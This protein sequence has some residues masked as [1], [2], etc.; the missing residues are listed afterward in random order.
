MTKRKSLA[1][2]MQSVRNGHATPEKQIPS[3]QPESTKA[4]SDGHMAKNQNIAPSRLGKK[5]VG[6]YFSL[7]V[8]KQLKILAATEDSSVQILLGKALNMLFLEHG[9]NPIAGEK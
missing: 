7:E 2:A 3:A 9:M 4:I 6:G 8:S 5:F 1:S